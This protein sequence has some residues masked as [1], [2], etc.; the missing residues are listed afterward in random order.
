MVSNSTKSPC[1]AISGRI[2]YIL[3][4][5]HKLR[6][7]SAP[8]LDRTLF[9]V[10]RETFTFSC[11]NFWCTTSEHRFK[12]SLVASIFASISLDVL[13]GEVCG[14]ELLVG[15]SPFLCQT[16]FLLLYHLTMVDWLYPKYRATSLVLLPFKTIRIANT[17][18]F[19]TFSFVVYAMFIPYIFG[20]MPRY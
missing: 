2:G 7:L 3:R 9:T 12:T 16:S 15:S 8:Y 13:L 5:F 4:F 6:F 19:P 14:L 18:T 10:E 17:R 20:V 1:L 11:F